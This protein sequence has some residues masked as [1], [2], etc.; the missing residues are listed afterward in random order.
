VTTGLVLTTAWLLLSPSVL[1]WYALW[2]LPWLVLREAPWAL[3]FT[4]TCGLAYLVYPP[5]L[6]G[7]AWQVAPWVRAC[8]YGPA[9]LLGLR[10]L[11]RARALT[12][13]A[14]A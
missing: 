6:L 3:A 13:D 14:A 1:P 12:A 7:G 5:W 9:L 10:A 2:L 4:L 11:L 8:E